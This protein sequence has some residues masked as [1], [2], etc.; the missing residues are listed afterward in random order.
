MIFFF[1]GMMVR[2]HDDVASRRLARRAAEIVVERAPARGATTFHARVPDRRAAHRGDSPASTRGPIGSRMRWW[3][4]ILASIRWRSYRARA[5]VSARASCPAASSERKVSSPRVAVPLGPA[6]RPPCR[7]ASAARE[8]RSSLSPA[9]STA[10]KL[11][12]G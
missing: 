2:S 5:T 10:A 11:M 6:N 9:T 1:P 4:I 8:A 3:K 7:D 12:W